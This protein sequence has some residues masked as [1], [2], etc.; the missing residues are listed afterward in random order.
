MASA[1]ILLHKVLTH[2]DQMLRAHPERSA[3]AQASNTVFLN[4]GLYPQHWSLR[5]CYLTSPNSP[6]WGGVPVPIGRTESEGFEGKRLLRSCEALSATF[7][8]VF[9]WG[10]SQGCSQLLSER[11]SGDLSAAMFSGQLRILEYG[12]LEILPEGG[13]QEAFA[14]SFV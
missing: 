13:I 14:D 4:P 7:C 1:N 2:S 10:G 12:V 5:A 9:L 11:D 6:G 8:I 3:V